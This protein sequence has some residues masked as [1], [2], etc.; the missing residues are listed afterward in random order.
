MIRFTNNFQLNEY[1]TSEKILQMTDPLNPQN[2]PIIDEIFDTADGISDKRIFLNNKPQLL[3]LPIVPPEIINDVE[4][5]VGYQES[6][7]KKVFADIMTNFISSEKSFND[8]NQENIARFQFLINNTFTV[9]IN[10]YKLVLK[11]TT[12][13]TILENDILFIYK[14]GTT[15]KLLFDKYKLLFQSFETFL[16]LEK[17]FTRSDSDYS[18][19]INPNMHNFNDVYIQ[20][21]KISACCL[22]FIKEQILANPD[23]FV[24]LSIIT[25]DDIHAKLDKMNSELVTMKTEPENTPYCNKLR[26][27]DKII[28]ISY[29][30]KDMFTEAIP[31]LNDTNVDTTFSNVGFDSQ[32]IKEFITN[33]KIDTTRSD[34]YMTYI[35]KIEE[36]VLGTLNIPK[37]DIYLSL[38]ETNE[39]YQDFATPITAA[40]MSEEI[41][42]GDI[43]KAITA[44]KKT[45]GTR[46]EANKT[47]FCLH[48]LKI[49][50]VTYYKT[51]PDING[52]V[53]YGYFSSPSELVDVSIMKSGTN[54]LK[55]MYKYIDYEFTKYTNIFKG[56]SPMDELEIMFKSYSIYGHISDLCIVLFVKSERPWKSAKYGKRL[57]RLLY[58]LILEILSIG[59]KSL[60]LNI[61]NKLNIIINDTISLN[62]LQGEHQKD[63]YNHIV[64]QNIPE[65]INI[66]ETR[67]TEL[68]TR[69]IDSKNIHFAIIKFLNYYLELLRKINLS[70]TD[71]IVSLTDFNIIIS[72]FLKK[73]I[74]QI[75]IMK[76]LE[77]DNFDQLT[78]SNENTI[79][80]THLGGSKHNQQYN[81]QYKQKYLKYKAKYL[82]LKNNYNK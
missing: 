64:N 20:V 61:I 76:Q 1:L 69:I 13:P 35:N 62:T 22:L 24:P 78:K 60:I 52:I 44:A 73:S 39:Y 27:V 26:N 66:L 14:G 37:N 17:F 33:R 36:K 59:H 2:R 75:V 49:N 4:V 68:N 57:N 7:C 5:D 46:D 50:F 72:D 18:I 11:E 70:D 56:K 53:K 77:S 54:D 12:N 48:R 28:G 9:A 10:K 21:N 47:A 6:L 25:D 58:F 71:D 32:Q 23:F 31:V 79:N 3:K 15:M 34:F 65:L 63:K 45:T 41:T 43:T 40:G 30:N 19:F 80:L 38:N 55:T 29:F 51:L 67:Q 82:N 81:Q 16:E 42:S 74:P 8:K